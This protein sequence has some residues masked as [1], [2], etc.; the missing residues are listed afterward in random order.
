[1]FFVDTNLLVYPHDSKGPEKQARA[2]QIMED[3]WH[4]GKGRLSFQVLIEFYAVTTRKLRPGL[5]PAIA[6][7]EIQDLLDWQPLSPSA[8]LL[9]DAWRIED[10]Y[11]LSWWDSLIVAAALEAK[12]SRL[13]TEDLQDGL[14]IDTLQVSNGLGRSSL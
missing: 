6:R 1:M 5:E 8:A 9:D 10:R 7:L 13:L 11:G 14:Q 2:T 3:L 12:C 4:S